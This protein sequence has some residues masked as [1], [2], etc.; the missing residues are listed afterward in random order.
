MPSGV[1]PV[2]D[3]RILRRYDDPQNAATIRRRLGSIEAAV[4][5]VPI[6]GLVIS[7]VRISERYPQRAGTLVST[8]SASSSASS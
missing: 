3:A 8:M 5:V 1:E 2:Q 7:L 4:V 6:G